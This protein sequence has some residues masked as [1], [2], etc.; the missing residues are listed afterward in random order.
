MAMASN[1]PT[2]P[3]TPEII[4]P[5]IR[6]FQL[7]DLTGQGAWLIQRICKIHPHLND[8]QVYSWLHSLI[9]STEFMVL[10]QHH[11]VGIVQCAKFY[12]LSSRPEVHEHFVF[13]EDPK[14]EQQVED[15]AMMY[16]EFMR[17]AKNKDANVFLLGE[18]SDVPLETI[19][20][21]LGGRVFTRTLS[22]VKV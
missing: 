2:L 15:A 16:D 21:H 7:P 4:Q 19:R 5:E 13:V 18:N 9:Y 3:G 22:F 10:T 6:R 11:A 12:S 20:K 14:S 17:W 8:R 1:A